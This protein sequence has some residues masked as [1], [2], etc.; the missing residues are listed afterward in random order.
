MS[1]VITIGLDIAKQVFHAHGADTTGATV[2]S[3][4]VTRA[5]LIP[6]LRHSR[7]GACQQDGTDNLGGAR[8]G[9]RITELQSLQPHLLRHA[10]VPRHK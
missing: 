5:K 6:F 7:R 10:R 9:R 8:Q 3:R 4:R 1:E 2:F